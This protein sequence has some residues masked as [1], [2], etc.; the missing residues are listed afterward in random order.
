MTRASD[1]SG[2]D[3]VPEISPDELKARM[4]RDDLVLVDVR[5]AYERKIA[6]LPDQDQLRIPVGEFESRLD[7][8]DTDREIVCYCRSGS[9]SEWAVERLLEA[10]HDRVWNL[11]GGLLAWRRDVD[12]SMS[13]Y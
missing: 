2:R 5:E 3:E 6:D 13:A 1:Q 9:R 7:E 8:L 12:P 10:G 11:K 4:D